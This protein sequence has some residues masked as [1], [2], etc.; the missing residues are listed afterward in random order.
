MT[1]CKYLYTIFFVFRNDGTTLIKYQDIIFLEEG[2]QSKKKKN[3][4]SQK[5]TCV[6]VRLTKQQKNVYKISRKDHVVLSKKN[7]Q[8]ETHM[9]FDHAG[10]QT[11]FN[12]INILE[13]MDSSVYYFNRF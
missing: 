8:E 5:F 12:K 4:D 11:I 10:V 1:S 6:D 7:L 9:C 13:L 3:N 2:Y